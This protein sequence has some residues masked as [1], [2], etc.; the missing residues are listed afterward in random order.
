[1]EKEQEVDFH[2]VHSTLEND[3][4]LFWLPALGFTGL[5]QAFVGF[6]AKGHGKS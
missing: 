3:S 1:M 4:V 5:K 2:F 6:P